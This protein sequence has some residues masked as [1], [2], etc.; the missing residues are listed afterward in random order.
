[1]LHIIVCNLYCLIWINSRAHQH[2]QIGTIGEP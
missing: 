1:M 2:Q